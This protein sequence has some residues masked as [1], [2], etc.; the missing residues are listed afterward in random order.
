[1][2]S[3]LIAAIAACS[4]SAGTADA[5]NITVHAEG[6]LS[7][8]FDPDNLLPFPEPGAGAVFRLSFTYDDQTDDVLSNDPSFGLYLEPFSSFQLEIAGQVFSPLS[9]SR[10]DVLN[11]FFL[12]PP[13][14]DDV[15]DA[16]VALTVNQD[17]TD[18]PDVDRLE[19]FFL[20]LATT[21][22]AA[23]SSIL[24]SDTLIPP[25]GPQP[26][27]EAIITYRIQLT[28]PES[29]GFITLAEATAQV[30]SITVVPVPAAF[31]LLGSALCAAACRRRFN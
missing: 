18:A 6:V 15:T 10:I 3:L 27:D 29:N 30:T 23:P 9:M 4:V 16:W 17:L 28:D 24:N 11:N 8:F 22:S 12:V 20:G 19:W 25:F 7:E 31:W 26:W 13:V 5:A 14:D 21:T 2:R 1:M